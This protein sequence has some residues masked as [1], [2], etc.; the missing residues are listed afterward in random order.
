MLA[1]CWRGAL[2]EIAVREMAGFLR[3]SAIAGYLDPDNHSLLRTW[4]RESRA[5]CYDAELLGL[6]RCDVSG[7][8]AC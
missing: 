5:L 8:L 2:S 3:M 1:M 4:G 7:L 6:D